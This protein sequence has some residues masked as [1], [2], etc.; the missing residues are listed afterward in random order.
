MTDDNSS[1]GA[2]SEPALFATIH[3]KSEDRPDGYSDDD[4][5][6][7]NRLAN[8]KAEAP[9]KGKRALL[10]GGA[11]AL[12]IMGLA[13]SAIWFS[14]TW[15][16]GQIVRAA[17]SG[18][19]AKLEQ[20]VDFQAVRSS[21][22]ADLKDTMGA[23]FRKEMAA[24]DDPFVLLFG[25]LAS[26]MLD[27]VATSMAEQLITPRT[28]EKAASGQEVQ[29]DLLGTSHDLQFDLSSKENLNFT[30]SGQYLSSSRYEYQLRSKSTD[31]RFYVQMQRTGPF[32][33]R[34]DR[35]RFDPDWARNLA[36]QK[37]DQT[38]ASQPAPLPAEPQG[39]RDQTLPVFSPGTLY[40]DFRSELLR[41]GYSPAPQQRS[42]FEVFC[43]T[44][45]LD[46]GEPDLCIAYP[47]VED[48]AG[49]SSRPCSFL[50]R[51]AIDG[52][53][54]SVTTEG[55]LFERITVTSAEWRD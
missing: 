31:D 45:Y 54:L 1:N 19:R 47:E 25:G 17:K 52:R 48:C 37:S 40:A 5:G 43:G 22:E 26:G 6:E 32:S 55:E 42:G 13:G 49:T 36:S 27:N 2:G 15:T 18:D 51:R 24:T 4:I 44:E 14:P 50:F 16:P 53:T 21:F 34:V 12:V 20:L 41:S 7:L 10:A 46:P 3:H 23:A 38:T 35:F 33:W 28:L 9:L 29:F 8:G 39:L 30:V 11:A